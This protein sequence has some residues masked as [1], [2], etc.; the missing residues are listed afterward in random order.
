[1]IKVI[2]KRVT[3]EVLNIDEWLY[4]VN[5]IDEGQQWLSLEELLELNKRFFF[6]MEINI[7]VFSD[8]E[9]VQIIKL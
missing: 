5:V 6:D 7:E 1:M 3:N 8:D 2:R 4:Y 9:E